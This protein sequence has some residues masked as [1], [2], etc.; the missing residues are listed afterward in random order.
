MQIKT[1]GIIC[2]SVTLIIMAAVMPAA[3]AAGQPAPH[4]TFPELVH[5]FGT[6]SRGDT[7]SHVF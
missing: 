6:I 7:V 1:L 3:P 5:D 4:I 2:F